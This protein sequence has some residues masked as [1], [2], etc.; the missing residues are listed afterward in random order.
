MMLATPAELKAAL[1]LLDAA[2]FVRVLRGVMR[3]RP[4][5]AA[6]GLTLLQQIQLGVWEWLT[7]LGCVSDA[8]RQLLLCRTTPAFS[9]YAELLAN[10]HTSDGDLR[11]DSL[12]VFS[13]QL[14]DWRFAGWTG[15]GTWVDLLFQELQEELASPPVTRVVCDLSAM[16]CRIHERLAELR[17]RSDATRSAESRVV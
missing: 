4:E 13:L 1:P 9:A 14:A 12:P 7:H 15:H 2:E 11:R 3:V 8:Q 16:Y 10:C 17:K 5:Q 6:T